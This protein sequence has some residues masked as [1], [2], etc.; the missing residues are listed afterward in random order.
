MSESLQSHVL[1]HTRLPCPSPTPRVYSNSC[2]SSRQCHP[3]ISSS[4]VPFSCLGSPF[5]GEAWA[6]YSP[7]G[8]KVLDMAKHLCTYEVI[9][10]S[11]VIIHVKHLDFL[12]VMS[13]SHKLIN[14]Y[15]HILLF[16][17]LLWCSIP[18]YGSQHPHCLPLHPWT[19]NYLRN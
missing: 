17:W 18:S 16:V 5:S 1:Q 3:A 12:N 7:W 9:C 13:C 6:G 19:C 14:G 2:P 15:C 4:V 10:L 8:C 11:F